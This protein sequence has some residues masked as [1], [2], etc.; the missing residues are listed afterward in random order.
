MRH[1]HALRCIQPAVSPVF[2]TASKCHLLRSLSTQDQHCFV[3]RDDELG[4]FL[5]AGSKYRKY[6]SLIP[7][8]EKS[9]FSHVIL[10]GYRNGNNVAALCQL[11]RQRGFT[12]RLFLAP[13]RSDPPKSI[14]SQIL[15]LLVDESMIQPVSELPR[16]LGSLHDG[17]TYFEVEEG[18]AV[19][20]S[21]PGL[22]C[23]HPRLR[24]YYY[25]SSQ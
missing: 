12:P 5:Y 22:F 19:P 13:S 8:L 4:S 17:E 15:S 2:P 21:V 1:A 9:N 25:T 3:K 14:N 18:S 16:F 6:A 10:K 20:Q 23:Y 11:L 7:F 24:L